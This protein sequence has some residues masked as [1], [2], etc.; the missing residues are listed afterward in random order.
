MHKLNCVTVYYIIGYILQEE[1]PGLYVAIYKLC[2]Y[3]ALMLFSTDLTLRIIFTILLVAIFVPNL[4]ET[5]NR[6]C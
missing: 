5:Y 1:R 2:T 4:K 3:V 6:L